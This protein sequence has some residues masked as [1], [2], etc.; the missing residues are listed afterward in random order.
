MQKE[1]LTAIPRTE[2]TTDLQTAERSE[3]V[4]V[5]LHSPGCPVEFCLQ[6]AAAFPT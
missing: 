1:K 3:Q 2:S 5:C 6:F 4:S